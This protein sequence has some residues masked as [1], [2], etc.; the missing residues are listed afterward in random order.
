V[1]DG[2]ADVPSPHGD[3]TE[4]NATNLPC[5]HNEAITDVPALVDDIVVAP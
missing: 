5:A 2:G 1:P 4:A 3:G